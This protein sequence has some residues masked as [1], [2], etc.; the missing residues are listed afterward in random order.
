[1]PRI[2]TLRTSRLRDDDPPRQLGRAG[3]DALMRDPRRLDGNHPEHGPVVDMIQ[4][5]FDLVFA[6]P[7]TGVRR[8]TR[9][10]P[11]HAASP[12]RLRTP[13]A[14]TICRPRRGSNTSGSPAPRVKKGIS[15]YLPLPMKI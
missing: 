7:D 15:K 9:A 3:L 11:S 5:G 8:P 1:M 6:A 2:P 13:K 12:I 4:R 14:L 10:V